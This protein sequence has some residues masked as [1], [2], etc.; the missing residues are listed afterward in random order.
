MKLRC[1]VSAVV[2]VAVLVAGV[3]PAYAQVT[4]F[5]TDVAAAIDHGLAYLDSAGAFNNPSSAWDAAGLVLLALLEKRASADP[6]DPPQGYSGADPADQARMERVVT[7]IVTQYWNSG[8]YA[9][10]DGSILMSLS[11]Y[12]RT[13]GPEVHA[14]QS[15]L[16]MLN[17]V[18]DRINANQS[19]QGYWCY[20]GWWCDD[21][22]TTQLV[23]AGLAAVRGVYS[24]P[25]FSDPGRLAALDVLTAN[26]RTGYTTY[27]T[28]G[29]PGGVLT[30]TERGHG[31]NR[32]EW[33][34]HQQTASGLWIQLVGGAD[35]NDASIQNYLRWLYH[36]YRYTDISGSAWSGNSYWYY[37]WS[38]AKAYKFLEDSGV[39][40][41]AG[42]IDVSAIGT[43][44][45][46]SAPGFAGR[47][48]HR[49]PTAD[50]QIAKFGSGGPGYYSAHPA[51]VYY[52]YAYTL[53]SRQAGNGNFAFGPGSWNTYARNAYALLVL[54][55]SVGG[56]IIDTDEDGIADDEDNCPATPNADQLD[57]D[58]D[59]V[60][61]VCDAC[62]GADDNADENNNQIPDC[63]ENA[64]PDIQCVGE[65]TGLVVVSADAS[66]QADVNLDAGTTDPDGDLFDF[67]QDP[68]SP[69]GLGETSVL[70]TATDEHGASAMCAPI[71]VRVV[72]D[73]PPAI[74][75]VTAT[76][77]TLWPPN[78]KMVGVAVGV[79]LSDNCGDANAS[80]TITNVT[81]NEPENGLG[82][83][84][85]APDWEITGDLTV[86]LRAERAGNGSGRIY[87]I[88][89]SCTDLAGNTS[90]STVEVTVPKSQ[91]RG[92]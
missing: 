21:S 37:L 82:D 91:G 23:V 45:S 7:H 54:E 31:Y 43:L 6:S 71:T 50:L 12:L 69:Y 57:S 70:A 49:D 15:V 60:G 24:D 46:G 26:S 22:S 89:V 10:R 2:A 40:P 11:V 86:D 52:D 76:P 19:G 17:R 68:P 73:T 39:A 77:N 61:D 13:G 66:C 33:P 78:H 88:T 92:R 63:L 1:L 3:A 79:D 29:G 32:G 59:G 72:D 90:S 36:R 56:G 53:L 55:R 5:S 38:S 75:G 58:G 30:P 42:N 8:F 64:A 25:L 27:A 84:D 51:G 47:Q 81:S 87:T 67:V 34:S 16:G 65:D 48:V 14:T 28:Q 85:T 80:C 44:P 20:T 83:G 9:Y 18:F 35:L 62:P 74:S 4:E 41:A